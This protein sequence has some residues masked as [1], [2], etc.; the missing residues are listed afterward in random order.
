MKPTGRVSIMMNNLILVLALAA[1]GPKQATNVS[2]ATGDGSATAPPPDTR[3]EIEKRRDG[4]CETLGP[5]ITTCALDDAKKALAAGQ[6]KQKDFDEN[7]K[8]EILKKN[9]EEFI[10][11]CKH[12][13]TAYSSRQIRVLEVCQEQESQCEPLLACLDNLNKP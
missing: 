6:V 1:C 2:N 5:K 3:S 11:K 8:P 7:T 4:A 10:D 9:T 12:P 13:K